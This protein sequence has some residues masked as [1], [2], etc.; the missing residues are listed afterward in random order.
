M[1]RQDESS[2]SLQVDY[3][4]EFHAALESIRLD[5]NSPVS[6]AGK[7]ADEALKRAEVQAD[8]TAR[9]RTAWERFLFSLVELP[10]W[11]KTPGKY[12]LVRMIC[13]Q[14]SEDE[15]SA[16]P[17][18]ALAYFKPRLSESANPFLRARYAHVLWDRRADSGLP[19]EESAEHGRTAC[20]E[21]IRV[22]ETA[23][24]TPDGRFTAV[25]AYDIAAS[26]SVELQDAA[27]CGIAVRSM[28]EAIEKESKLSYAG[29]ARGVAST[30]LHVRERNIGKTAVGDEALNTVAKALE[31]TANQPVGE[32]DMTQDYLGILIRVLTVLGD[33]ARVKQIKEKQAAIHVFWADYMQ[34]WMVMQADRFEQA[35]ALYRET[36]NRE[37]VGELMRRSRSANRESVVRGEFKGV[38]FP[39]ELDARKLEE[40]W[41]R[42]LGQE[43]LTAILK[44]LASDND[45]VPSMD[46]ATRAAEASPGE[47][48]LLHDIPQSILRGDRKKLQTRGGDDN[49][50]LEFG[51]AMTRHISFVVTFIISPV[52]ARMKQS[53]GLDIGALLGFLERAQPTEPVRG[54]LEVG[55][56]HYF[57]GEFVSASYVLI[58]AFERLVRETLLRHGIDVTPPRKGGF[59][60][61]MLGAL[62]SKEE[63]QNL[64]GK[65]VSEYLTITLLCEDTGGRNLRNDV[66]HGILEPDECTQN[67]ADLIL[68]MFLLMTRYD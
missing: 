10:I 20:K 37:R 35:A 56:R 32:L 42:Y 40:I 39:F 66:A 38:G 28:L 67:L 64:L 45:L 34:P 1:K 16:L 51:H 60:E 57:S 54:L 47:A 24:L 49:T 31:R 63:A 43:D 30:L 12:R 3:L 68:F 21:Y 18:D 48:T 65:R 52:L 11:R 9:E 46:E 58:P 62:L 8:A 6:L 14:G 22:A 44:A 53:R 29:L 55:L 25:D 61:S 2:E 7:L 59:R 26:I 15:A 23:S 4:Q 50:Q 5:G 33:D 36:G 13:V 19:A 41:N 27:L 17:R